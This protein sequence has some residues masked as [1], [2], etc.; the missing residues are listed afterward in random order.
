MS[1]ASHGRECCRD[2]A[3]C[4][5][6]RDGECWYFAAT[7][8]AQVTAHGTYSP[9]R[10]L[11]VGD[12][13]VFSGTGGR[14]E[15]MIRRSDLVFATSSLEVGY[16]DPEITLVYQHYSPGNLASFIQRKGRG[17]RGADDRPVTGVTLSPYSSRD[18]WYFRRPGRM[19][20][21]SRFE[22][23]VNLDNYF[24]LRGQA[25]AVVLDCVARFRARNLRSGVD[26]GPGGPVL[27]PAVLAD[28]DCAVRAVCG[29]GVYEALQVS[30]LA[31][32][33]EVALETAEAPLALDSEP[34]HWRSRLPWVPDRLF[35]E[36]NLPAISV[37]FDNDQRREVRR[38]ALDIAFDATAPGNMT[39]RYGWRTLHW[40]LPAN[41]RSPW[42]PE[43]TYKDAISLP[44]TFADIGMRELLRELPSTAREEIGSDPHHGVCTPNEMPLQTAGRMLGAEWLSDWVYDSRT[45]T[46]ARVERGGSHPRGLLI[47]HK[48][49][50]NL[51]AATWVRSDETL[52]C[53]FPMRG[54]GSL[55][56]RANAFYGGD[57]KGNRTGLTVGRVFWGADSELRLMD[58]KSD[59]VPMTQ[60][61]THP[62]S[63]K[64][65]LHGY[66]VETE[67]L[68]LHLDSEK[69]AKFVREEAARL[70]EGPDGRWYRGQFLRFLIG[71]GA[72]SAGLN[73][74]E[75]ERAAE[76]LFSVAG[77]P[78][79][80]A[81]LGS[82]MRRWDSRRLRELLQRTYD[83]LLGHHPLLTSARIERL[84]RSLGEHRFQAL[85][86]S[87]LETMRSPEGFE[88]YLHSVLVHSLALRIK[89]SFVLHGR[90]EDRRVVCH[91]KLPMQF[92]ADA[93]DVIT[94]AE[95]GAHGDGTTRTFAKNLSAVLEEWRVGSLV[96][97][98]NAREDALV[99]VVHARS[100]RH[101]TWRQ[102]DS[103][104]PQ[105]I[106]ALFSELGL[107]LSAEKS[108]AHGI[109]TLLFGH[110][111]AGHERFAVFD[112]FTETR[113][114]GEHLAARLE[115]PPS[116]WELTS[117]V[118]NAAESEAAET[119]A[120]TRLWKAYDA[121]E[122]AAHE[123]SLSSAARVA[124]QAYRLSGR[125]CVDGCQGCLHLG[126]DIVSGAVAEALLSRGLL[127]R[128][129]RDI[130]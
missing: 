54:F 116:T 26:G 118:A 79:L 10:P 61:F 22:V 56:S 76:L 90:G 89:Q 21:S 88:A 2:P 103:R 25:L 78:E 110:E 14:V 67:G 74:Y 86:R 68:R 115:R 7:D 16:D 58:P 36:I 119:P 46:V 124:D 8:T 77:P 5:T 105:E 18:S 23:P 70:R 51:R 93:E 130:L 38:E 122:D 85:F 121:L 15:E 109:V 107:D 19:L 101:A 9:G 12:R 114:V 4:D 127:E 20:D 64:T 117:A 102:I 65:L 123:E 97:C 113:A 91:A 44:A 66:H 59:D 84:A 95:S 53:Q 6:F 106:E 73:G 43:P 17:G 83:E 35:D 92:G 71:S 128:F 98:P 28:A 111:T 81:E 82:L 87:S 31:E 120:F 52:A 69:I 112:L 62:A 41:G 34:G 57:T 40:T 45:A 32:F 125:L 24:V 29:D 96:E 60:V 47:H 30:N 48:S 39:R 126:S 80:R 33:W 50:G 11:T 37:A 42:L 1:L 108:F 104:D 72:R 3:S 99:D 100:D 55:V 94:I 49:R 13:P 27:P 63:R 129:L 75:A